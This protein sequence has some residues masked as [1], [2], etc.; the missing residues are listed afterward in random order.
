MWET[1]T[2][3]PDIDSHQPPLTYL[4]PADIHAPCIFSYLASSCHVL[5]NLVL[6]CSIQCNF[7]DY[8][9]C[10]P[11][12]KCSL[13]SSRMPEI[14]KYTHCCCCKRSHL[15][16]TYTGGWW[17]WWKIESMMGLGGG[18]ECGNDGYPIYCSCAI[19]YFQIIFKCLLFTVHYI[20]INIW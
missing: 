19:T 4:T 10:D 15:T 6:S 12:P 11:G 2:G 13:M 14:D 7:L 8:L 9:C 20:Y 16:F 18:R 5:S 17:Q 1:I 3:R